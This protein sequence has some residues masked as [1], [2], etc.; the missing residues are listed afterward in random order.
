MKIKL[1]IFEGSKTEAKFENGMSLELWYN[2]N[3]NY[4]DAKTIMSDLVKCWN[5]HDEML[6][7][8]NVIRDLIDKGDLIRD[9]SQ[10]DNFNYFIKQGMRITK[11]VLLMNEAIKKATE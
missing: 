3:K 10:D 1:S 5:M 2:R 7:A 9:I 4:E 11:A 6:E 8:L